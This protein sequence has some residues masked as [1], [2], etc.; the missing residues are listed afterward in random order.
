MMLQI[1]ICRRP[2]SVKFH[3]SVHGD[4]SVMFVMGESD[5]NGKGFHF[6]N[7]GIVIIPNGNW[8]I[9]TN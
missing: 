9:L 7:S 8:L 6:F 4:V 5:K 1:C 3:I 2:L